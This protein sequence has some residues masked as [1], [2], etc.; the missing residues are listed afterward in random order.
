MRKE[1]KPSRI[2]LARKTQT[3]RPKRPH[4]SAAKSSKRRGIL[5]ATEKSWRKR[6]WGS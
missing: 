2:Y 4:K 3:G 6:K 1:K 5:A